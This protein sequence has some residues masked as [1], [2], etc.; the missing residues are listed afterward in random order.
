VTHGVVI[1]APPTSVGTPTDGR[2][3]EST[4]YELTHC[5]A[6]A[7]MGHQKSTAPAYVQDVQ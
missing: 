4:G 7:C 1:S 2:S 6:T 3:T 5:V